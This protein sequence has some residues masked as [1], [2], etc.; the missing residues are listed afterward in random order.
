MVA[1]LELLFVLFS[2]QVT[3]PLSHLINVLHSMK[4]SMGCSTSASSSRKRKEIPSETELRCAE[5]RN[6]Q[7]PPHT[8]VKV[9]ILVEQ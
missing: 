4:P 6:A 3:V 2:F 7:K 8:Y 9:K 5:V 1:L